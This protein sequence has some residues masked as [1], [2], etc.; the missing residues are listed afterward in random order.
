MSDDE[1]KDGQIVVREW[2]D[3]ATNRVPL[4]QIDQMK[5][6]SGRGINLSFKEEE[7]G[8]DVEQRSGQQPRVFYRRELEAQPLIIAKPQPAQPRK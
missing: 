8:L 3:Y 7:R 1:P 2:L 5:K 6:A 4:M